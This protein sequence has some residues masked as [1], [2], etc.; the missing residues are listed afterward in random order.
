[1]KT[2]LFWYSLSAII[3]FLKMFALSTYQGIYRIN[4][5]TFINAED[6]R[7]FNKPA[8]SHELLQVQRAAKA[9]L[10]DLENIPIFLALGISYV[11]TGALPSAAPWLFMIFTVSRVLH[12][13]T[14]LFAIQPWRTVAYAVG[15]LSLFGICLN[16]AVV[17]L[18]QA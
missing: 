9:W 4:R 8:S 1:M 12:S 16:I 15:I 2:S 10:N 7:F 18:Y 5:R 11:L 6:A 17:L 13:I 14:Y 3:L